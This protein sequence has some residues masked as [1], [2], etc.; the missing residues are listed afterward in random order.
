MENYYF[1]RVKIQKTPE[2][3]CMVD[4]F[5]K[6]FVSQQKSHDRE[7]NHPHWLLYFLLSILPLKASASFFMP[8]AT[9]YLAKDYEAGY[10]NWACAQG[11]NGEMY[12]GNSQGLLVFDGY[13][14]TLYKVP[15]N[16]I[17][18]S[19]FV[20]EDRIYV[21]TFEEFGYFEYGEDGV[22]QYYSLSRLLKNFPMENNEIWNIVEL[23][24]H[25]YFQSFSAWFSYDGKMVRAFRNRQQ[26]PLYFYTQNGHI[27]TQ[28]IDEDFYEFDGKDFHHLFPRSKVNDDNVVALLPDGDNSFLMVTEN[29]GLFRYNGDIVSWKTDIDAE[30]KKQRVNRAVMTNDSIFMIGT[31]LNGIYAIDRKGHCLWHFNLDNRLCNNTVLGLFCD[32]DNNVWAAL[33]DGIAYI[34]HNSPVMLLTPANHEIKLGMVYDIAHRGNYF[35]LATNQGLYEYNQTTGNLRLLSHTE[36]QNWYVKDIDGQ[37]FAGNNAY[38]LLIGEKGDVSVISNTNSSTCLTKCILYG[39]EILLESSYADLRIYKKKNGQWIFSHIIDGFIAPVMHI[40]VDQSGIIWASH[41]YQG[42]YKIVL[43]DDLSKIKSVQHI[44]HLG[45]EYIVGPIQVMKMRGRIVFS[46]PNSFY[47]YDDITQQIIPFQKL[48]AILPYIKNAHSVVPVT[49]DRFWLS[50]SH[51]YVLVEYKDGEYIVKQRIPIELF[52][53]PCI[54]NYNNVFVDNDVVYF[55]LNNGIASYSKNTNSLSLAPE[56]TLSLSS[57]ICSSSDKKKK[58]LPLSVY[59]E[60]ESIYRDLLFAVSLPH[61]NKLP[62]RFHYVLQGG[63]GMTLTSD[64]KDPEIRYGSLDYGD[65]TFHAEAY[66]DLDQKIGEVGYH[67]VIARPFYLSYYAFVLYL[68]IFIALVCFFSKWRANRAMEKKQKEYEAEQVRQNIKMHE[69]EHLI[70][71]QQQQLLEAELFAKS[72]D[73]A[74]MALDV[75]TKNEVLEKL[76]TALQ[77]SLSKGQYGRKNLEFLLKIINENIDSQEFWDVFQNNFDLIHEK[78]FRNLRERYPSLTATDLRFCTLLRLNL[79]TKDIA[80]MTNLTIRGVEAARYRLRKKLNIPDGTGLVDFLIDLK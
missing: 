61:Y 74:N 50:G 11:K 41:M 5:R 14:W 25:I 23:E 32:K 33:D 49:N 30:L 48:N 56:C 12:F 46:S 68:M 9:N 15:G 24:S 47:T 2:I 8:T 18:R 69:Q 17:V 55:N 42:V 54:E 59:A 58:R 51:E 72:K 63:Q 57:V 35:Y 77:N 65:Y 45:S 22:L 71:I 62:V 26:Q 39:E 29:N 27:Y 44:F 79:S 4:D 1:C 6:G 80:Q 70:T 60:L 20:K 7:C 16:H 73:L 34:H 21:G 10:Q 52:D 43:S 78:F 28:M 40:E 36:G 75:F 37:L 3:Y 66:N 64:L 76:R 67:F 53:S 31:I 38:T 19:V 13:R